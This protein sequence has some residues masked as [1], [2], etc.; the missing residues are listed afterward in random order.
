MSTLRLAII[1]VVLTA[2]AGCTSLKK[3]NYIQ[4]SGTASDS[5]AAGAMPEFTLTIQPHDILSIQLFTI[6]AEAFPGIATTIDKQVIDN[7]SAYEKGFMVDASGSIE[8]PLVGK[9]TLSGYTLAEARDTIGNRYR[10][11]MDEPIVVLKKLSFK[12]TVLGEVNK[13]GLYYVPN[14][15][16]S[17]FEG[18]GMAGDLT[19]FGDRKTVKVIRRNGDQYREIHVDLTTKAPLHAEIAYLHPDDV[20]YVPT[21]RK[22]GATTVSPTVGIITSILATLTLMAALILRETE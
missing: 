18:L 15:K 17:F 3:M 2:F 4:D 11:F 21:T 6:N 19:P 14:E 5:A 13:P 16:I 20:I 8:L 9:L 1:A 7:R 22:R 10:Q 12:I